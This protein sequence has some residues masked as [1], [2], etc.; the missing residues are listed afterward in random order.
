MTK[1]SEFYFP[2]SDGRTNIH[3]EEWLP[4]GNVK[5]VLQVVHGVAEYVGRYAPFAEFLNEHGIA[6]IGDDHIGH[7]KSVAEGAARLY[8]GENDGW[9]HVV[10]DEHILLQMGKNKFPGVPYFI[11]GHSMGSF[12]TRTYLIRYP[13]NVDGAIIMGT[14]HQ[15]SALI[16]GGKLIGNVIAKKN[17]KDKTND[18]VTKLAFGSYNKAFAPTRTSCDWIS[19]NEENVDRYMADPLCGGDATV[20]LFLDMLGGISFLRKQEN[21]NKMDVTKPVLF[22]SGDKDPVGDFGKGVRAAYETFKKAGVSDLSI[23]LYPGLRHE[24]LNEKEK[25]KVYGYIL[26]WLEKRI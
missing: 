7:G 18:T 2:S 25:Q 5:A 16:A 10:D 8:F 1:H 15:S 26:N 6:V 11:M 23:K 19:A 21:V 12:I 22:I 3:A 24:I 13:G 4:E 9:K 17:G 20:G 14:G